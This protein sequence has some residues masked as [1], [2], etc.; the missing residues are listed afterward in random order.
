VR[1]AVLRIAE[2]QCI[3]SEV[4]GATRGAAAGEA[5]PPAA[6]N[7]GLAE[8]LAGCGGAAAGGRTAIGVWGE[9]LEHGTPS[10]RR[11]VP[12]GGEPAPRRDAAT[13]SW[14]AA[15]E[16]RPET[17]GATARANESAE[18]PREA[19]DERTR[20]FGASFLWALR[21]KNGPSLG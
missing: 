11:G 17:P 3:R 20:L 4:A 15:A 14:M 6:A 9:V 7:P 18:T 10:A 16:R 8:T 1:A 5:N 12:G 2:V 19:L 21:G 13:A